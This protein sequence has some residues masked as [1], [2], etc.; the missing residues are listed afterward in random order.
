MGKDN[1]NEKENVAYQGVS[2]T[3]TQKRRLKI[4]DPVV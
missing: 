4:E 2:K 1:I 3:K